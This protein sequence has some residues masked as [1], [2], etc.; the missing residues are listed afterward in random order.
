MPAPIIPET[1]SWTVIYSTTGYYMIAGLNSSIST[2]S[3]RFSLIDSIASF[4]SMVDCRPA[5]SSQG[6]EVL[7]R[8]ALTKPSSMAV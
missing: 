5:Y 4:A 1:T 2:G 7:F 3:A 8:I 6:E